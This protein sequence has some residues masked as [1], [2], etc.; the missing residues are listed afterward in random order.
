M[1]G[2][3]GHD[4]DHQ[5]AETALTVAE[6]I[7]SVGFAGGEPVALELEFA[8]GEGAADTAALIRKLG[9]FGYAA[10]PGGEAAGAILVTVPDVALDADAIWTHEERTTRIALL[11]GWRPEGWGFW[12]P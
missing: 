5:R 8:P 4:W 3:D 6:L 2:D 7:R 9:Q 11:H 12:E 1:T 10:A